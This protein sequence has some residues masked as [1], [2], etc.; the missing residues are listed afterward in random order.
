MLAL[1]ER[2]RNEIRTLFN[3]RRARSL[4]PIGTMPPEGSW[5]FR[6]NIKMLVTG[7]VD[8]RMWAWLAQCGWRKCTFPH[9][10]REYICLPRSAMVLLAKAPESTWDDLHSRMIHVASE[11][12][13]RKRNA[14]RKRRPR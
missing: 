1:I 10:R 6:S 13:L 9:D 12:H 11:H 7:R 2:I 14:S 4:P 5:I 8:K 3:I